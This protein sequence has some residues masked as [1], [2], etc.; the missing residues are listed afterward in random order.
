M[1][2]RSRKKPW[3]GGKSG[4]ESL[5]EGEIKL[6]GPDNSHSN[7][8]YNR[9][10]KHKSNLDGDRGN[11]AILFLLYLL[12]G[13]PLGLCAAIPMILQNKHVSYKDQVRKQLNIESSRPCLHCVNTL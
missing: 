11:I 7:K 3:G 9:N 1:S 4:K 8:H 12:Q 13:V 5:E 10:K 6:L 2:S